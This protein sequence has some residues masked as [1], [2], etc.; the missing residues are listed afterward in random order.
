[1][2]D[3]LNRPV[4]YTDWVSLR[5]DGS[6]V[7]RPPLDGERRYDLPSPGAGGSDARTVL[8]FTTGDWHFRLSPAF[9][10]AR[11]FQLREVNPYQLVWPASVSVNAR[12]FENNDGSP[13]YSSRGHH[14]FLPRLRDVL[15]VLK[16]Q[17]LAND[18]RGLYDLRDVQVKKV[19]NYWL[20]ITGVSCMQARGVP[21]EMRSGAGRWRLVAQRPGSMA[22]YYVQTTLQQKLRWFSMMQLFQLLKVADLD[23]HSTYTSMTATEH[24]VEV[25]TPPL[26]VQPAEGGPNRCASVPATARSGVRKIRWCLHLVT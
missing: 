4:G 13:I 9:L 1:V 15:L 3:L 23:S 11:I 17:G 20:K 16:T 10:L 2:A 18:S 5:V 22:L 12:L 19:G 8:E 14:P 21:E 7:L 25:E 24:V 6:F 26:A